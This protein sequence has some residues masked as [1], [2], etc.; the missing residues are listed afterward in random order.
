MT[1]MEQH[2]TSHPVFWGLEIIAN[3]DHVTHQPHQGMTTWT[4]SK[5]LKARVGEPARSSTPI[6][7][8]VVTVSLNVSLAVDCHGWH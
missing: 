4:V 1:Y 2:D 8:E 5:H 7:R 3:K 6:A